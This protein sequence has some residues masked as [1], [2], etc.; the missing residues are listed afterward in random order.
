MDEEKKSFI[1]IDRKMLKWE[2]YQDSN[3]KDLF[4]HLLLTANWESKKWQ[5]IDIER[6]S[7]ITSIKHLSEQT[8]LTIRQVRTS[9]DKLVLTNEIAKSSTSKYTVITINNYNKYQDYNKQN[10]KQMANQRQTNDNQTTTTKQYNNITNKQ[11][12]SCCCYAEEFFGRTLNSPE[13]KLISDWLEQYNEGLIKEA[14]RLTVV[15]GKKYLNYTTGILHNWEDRG[16]KTLED[17]RKNE[18]KEKEPVEVYEYDWL[19]EE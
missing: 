10:D 12:Y 4:L 2:W 14:I 19:N 5:G 6:G 11:L 17:I 9:L 7:L 18:K 1:V 8:G 15:S 16:Y 13:I 3:T